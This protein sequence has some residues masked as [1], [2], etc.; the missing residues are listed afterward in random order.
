[1]EKAET[2]LVDVRSPKEFTGEIT[3]PPEYPME[4]A[5]RGG[6]IPGAANVPWAQAIKEVDGTFKSVQE[7]QINL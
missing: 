7:S 2:A 6:H 5:Q 4:H 3:A 1:M